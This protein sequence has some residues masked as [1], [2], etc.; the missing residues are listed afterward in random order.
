MRFLIV[1]ISILCCGTVLNAQIAT[2]PILL[3]RGNT[4]LTFTSLDT[5]VIT[6]ADGDTIYLPGG[7]FSL[8]I[9]LTKRLHFFGT[10]YRS[11]ST[12]VIGNTKI[13]NNFNIYTGASGSSLNNIYFTDYIVTRDAVS[14][15]NINK[16]RVNSIQTLYNV[17]T[18]ITIYGSII[19]YLMMNAGTFNLSNSIL[20][21]PSGGN[22]GFNT[23]FN[24]DNSI[25]N[26]TVP[27]VS[28]VIDNIRY[29]DIRN[30]IILLHSSNTANLFSNVSFPSINNSL[31]IGSS[32]NIANYPNFL[33]TNTLRNTTERGNVFTS[34]DLATLVFFSESNNY[35]VKPQCQCSDKGIYSGPLSFSSVP[36][37]RIVDKNIQTTTNTNFLRFTFKV[38]S[39]N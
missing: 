26:N 9:N 35:N 38:K 31:L 10:G 27:G 15:L 21:D 36:N 29:V 30:S 33:T 39:D 24:V 6:A 20:Y 5:A 34:E 25:I 14:I 16:C 37:V 17:T 7:V 12:M 19:N 18:N 1:L 11:D 3:Q 28:S 32:S 4:S 13:A 23:F 8:S 22:L 2:S